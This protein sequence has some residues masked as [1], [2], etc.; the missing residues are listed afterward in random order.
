MRIFHVVRL[1][2]KEPRHMEA[3]SSW[4]PIYENGVVGIHITDLPRGG[5]QVKDDRNLIFLKDMLGLGHA[6]MED[7]DDI[8]VWCNDDVILDPKIQEWAMKDVAANGAMTMRRFE[9]EDPIGVHMGRELFAFTK[10]WLDR[11]MDSIPDFLI[12]C[13]FFDLVVA[14]YI[15]KQNGLKSTLDNMKEDYPLCEATERYAIHHAHKSS[16]AGINE[17]KYPGNLH[18]RQLA[19]DWCAENMPSLCL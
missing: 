11:H 3:F 15:R 13:P 12:G 18:N 6:C 19:K 5:K 10:E 14:A 9:P 17:F 1:F 4:L 7:K 8:L 16:W 2:G